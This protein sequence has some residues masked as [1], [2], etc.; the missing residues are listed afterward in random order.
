M[1]CAAASSMAPL[2]LL[3]AAAFSLASPSVARAGVPVYA[4]PAVRVASFKPACLL[5]SGIMRVLD[6]LETVG[7]LRVDRT[8]KLVSSVGVTDTEPLPVRVASWVAASE[9]PRLPIFYAR[10]VQLDF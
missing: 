10:M 4:L 6:S 2:Q 3:I 5:P 9:P 7:V 8:A 1:I